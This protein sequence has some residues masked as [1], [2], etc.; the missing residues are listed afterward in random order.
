MVEEDLSAQQEGAMVPCMEEFMLDSSRQNGYMNVE[1]VQLN[2]S[3]EELQD[4]E[5]ESNDY[6][7]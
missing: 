1:K 5:A 2:V 3:V 4:K 6:Y 7:F